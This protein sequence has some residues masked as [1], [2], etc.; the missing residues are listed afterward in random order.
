MKLVK[1]DQNVAMQKLGADTTVFNSHKSFEVIKDATTKYKP[2]SF[3]ILLIPWT[4]F[5]IQYLG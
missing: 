3:G 5:L 1:H 2:S 4:D